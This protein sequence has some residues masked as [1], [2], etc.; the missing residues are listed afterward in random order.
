MALV[1]VIACNSS[2]QA[3]VVAEEREAGP[4]LAVLDAAVDSGRD[5]LDSGT[6]QVCGVSATQ[7]PLE[8]AQAVQEYLGVDRWA[9]EACGTTDLC[10]E[11]EPLLLFVHEQEGQV[12]IMRCGHF[13]DERDGGVCPTEWRA[14]HPVE[15]VDAESGRY[16]IRTGFDDLAYSF[17]L[18]AWTAEVPA[19]RLAGQVRSGGTFRKAT[20]PAK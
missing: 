11:A 9:W 16:E 4:A 19:I 2:T 10:P 20:A 14:E 6:P 12:L 18:T 13:C 17:E 1:C 8:S 7:V 3:P 5:D 15:L